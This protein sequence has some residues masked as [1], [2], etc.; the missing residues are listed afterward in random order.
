MSNLSY[1]E[2]QNLIFATILT[3]FQACV[4]W[5]YLELSLVALSVLFSLN[6]MRQ[7]IFVIWGALVI[8]SNST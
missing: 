5:G 7:S 4:N 6:Y 8:I 2:L 1:E 3:S